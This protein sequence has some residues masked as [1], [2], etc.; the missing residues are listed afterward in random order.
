MICNRH[1]LGY[2]LAV[3][4]ALAALLIFSLS[5][6]AAEKSRVVADDYAIDAQVDPGTH[7]LRASARIHLIATDDTNFASFELH[8]ALR[9]IKVTDGNGKPLTAERVSQ[10]NSIRIALPET[11]RKG[12]TRVLNIE[13]EGTLQNADDSPVQ[14]VKRAYIGD[15]TSYLLYAGRWFPV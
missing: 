9:V 2:A 7:H 11:F 5:A 6:G 15:D 3:C 13:Y 8:N 12:E 10:E 1:R 14:G 4:L